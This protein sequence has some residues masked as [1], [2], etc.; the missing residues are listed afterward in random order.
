MKSV[1]GLYDE[2]GDFNTSI[3]VENFLIEFSIA[4]ALIVLIKLA[5]LLNIKI[6]KFV[7]H[8]T[9]YH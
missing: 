4:C 1:S 5:K 9:E 2:R 8:S 3:L 6:S 7:E